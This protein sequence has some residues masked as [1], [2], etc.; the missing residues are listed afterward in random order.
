MEEKS[1]RYCKKDY[2][3]E[4]PFSEYWGFC[5]DC[6]ENCII[7]DVKCFDNGDYCD[8]CGDLYCNKCMQDITILK[9]SCCNDERIICNKCIVKK[10][11]HCKCYKTKKVLRALHTKCII[12]ETYKDLIDS[13]CSNEKCIYKNEEFNMLC[14]KCVKY[15]CKCNKTFCKKCKDKMICCNDCSGIFC[16]DC[17]YDEYSCDC[18]KECAV[19]D[20]RTH[21]EDMESCDNCNI[22]LCS[23]CNKNNHKCKKTKSKKK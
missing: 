2:T 19:C 6:V 21:Y 7:C 13:K 5:F 8:K 1:C 14:K 3:N 12:C 22:K 18:Y 23:Y 4:N 20:E 16:E 17:C 9:F 10:E 11:Y 15:C